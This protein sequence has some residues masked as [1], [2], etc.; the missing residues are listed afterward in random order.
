MLMKVRNILVLCMVVA[1]AGCSNGNVRNTKPVTSKQKEVQRDISYPRY[2]R[3]VDEYDK[4]IAGVK[5]IPVIERRGDNPSVEFGPAAV[6]DKNGE[7]FIEEFPIKT[8]SSHEKRNA[9]RA[10][11]YTRSLRARTTSRTDVHIDSK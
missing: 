3:L 10:N 4:P 1:I 8:I 6:S 5:V 2:A 9:F 7:V 11:L